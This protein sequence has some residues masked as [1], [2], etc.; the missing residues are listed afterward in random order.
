MVIAGLLVFVC[1]K[2]HLSASQVFL[3]LAVM[4][5][6]VLGWLKFPALVKEEAKS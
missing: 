5:A 6:A 2:S 3:V 1:V 4:V